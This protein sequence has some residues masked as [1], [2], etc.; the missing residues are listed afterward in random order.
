MEGENDDVFQMSVRYDT[1]ER[2]QIASCEKGGLAAIHLRPGDIIR[3]VNDHQ[4]SSKEMLQFYIL[5]GITE[6]NGKVY[7]NYSAEVHFSTNDKDAFKN[8]VIL[9]IDESEG[10]KTNKGSCQICGVSSAYSCVKKIKSAFAG[11]SD[12]DLHV[13]N[14]GNGCVTVSW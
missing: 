8:S 7:S 6:N 10:K 5:E 3:D 1:R 13:H 4:I 12:Y 11:Q 9:S 14:D 2:V